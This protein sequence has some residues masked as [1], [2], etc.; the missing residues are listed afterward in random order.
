MKYGLRKTIQFSPEMWEKIR[1]TAFEQ[2]VTPSEVVRSA[3]EF[4]QNNAMYQ[5][6]FVN[7][8]GK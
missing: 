6:R 8:G 2:N 4:A 3:V 1:K 5:G 7:I